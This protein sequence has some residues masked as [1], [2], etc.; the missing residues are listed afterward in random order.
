[1]IISMVIRKNAPMEKSTC[2]YPHKYVYLFYP[3]P[4]RGTKG[5]LADYKIISS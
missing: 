4:E 1:M 5:T 2:T 3:F